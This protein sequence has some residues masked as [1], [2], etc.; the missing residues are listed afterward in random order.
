MIARSADGDVDLFWIVGGNFLET[1]PD[2]GQSRRALERPRLRVHQ[3][4][5]MSSSMLIDGEG[6]VLLLPATTRYESPGGGTETSTE[7]RII[8]SPEIPGRRIGSAK[9]EWWVFREVMRRARPERAALVGLDDAAAIRREI[10]RASPLYTGIETLGR[11]GDHVQWGGR[12]LY[13]DGRFATNDGKAHFAPVSLRSREAT[14][15][16]FLVST[17]RGKQFNS[18]VQRAIDPLTGAGRD[19]VLISADDLARL[20]LENGT[21][22]RLRSDRGT[23]A[24]HLRVAPMRPGNL[25]VHWPE[26]NTLLSNTQLDPESMEPD[27]N[28]V[29]E[30][31]KA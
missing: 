9:P 13:A 21:A 24:G 28:A 1:L 22:V 10:A 2:V 25:E 6:D 5:V 20:G 19:D 7:R 23:F 12:T 29:V 3:D 14:G 30:I 31:E 27:Y 17:R 11:K 18:M 4:I 15:G 8:Y 26:G 16:R